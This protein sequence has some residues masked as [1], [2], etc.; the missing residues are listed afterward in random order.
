MHDETNVGLID[1]LTRVILG[2][3]ILVSAELL[4]VGVFIQ[5]LMIVVGAIVLVTGFAGFCLFY[6]IFGISSCKRNR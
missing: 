5:A 6:K 4:G 2:L 1:R 3:T